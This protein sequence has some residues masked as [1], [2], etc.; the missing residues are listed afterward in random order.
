[1]LF[2]ELIFFFA[3]EHQDSWMRMKEATNNS[4]FIDPTRSLAGQRDGAVTLHALT[5]LTLPALTRLCQGRSAQSQAAWYHYA[6]N[7]LIAGPDKQLE[8][9]ICGALPSSKIRRPACS[10]LYLDWVASQFM[11]RKGQ[12]IIHYMET[13]TNREVRIKGRSG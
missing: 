1:M 5:C 9:A 13:R 4:F 10:A 6:L 7:P 3:K 11:R 2:L 12:I 8:E